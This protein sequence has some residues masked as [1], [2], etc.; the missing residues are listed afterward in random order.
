MMV[1]GVFHVMMPYKD[2]C[3][4]DKRMCVTSR[5]DTVVVYMVTLTERA[6]MKRELL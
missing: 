5:S 2:G 3:E 6:T 4:L 1:S